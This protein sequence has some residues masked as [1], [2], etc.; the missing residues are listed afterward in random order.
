MSIFNY[1]AKN[2]AGQTIRGKVEAVN[3]QI[4]ADIL[5][6]KNLFVIKVS[7]KR[8]FFLI[9]KIIE[10]FFRRIKVK[11]EVIFFRQLSVLISAT[12]PLV[13]ALNILVKQTP[14]KTFQKVILDIAD[15]VEGGSRL[16]DSLAKYPQ[17]FNNFII[18]MIKSGETSGKLEEVLIYLANQ[19]EQDYDL[20][21]KIR[22][23][24]I[25][26]AFVFVMLIVVGVIVMVF[27]IPKLTT[28]FLESETKLPLATLILISISQFIVNFWWLLLFI[29]LVVFI[30]F[31]LYFKT[32][33]GRHQR[34]VLKLKLPLLGP[35][36]QRIYLVRFTRSFATL[37]TG[38]VMITKALE[39]TREVVG[40]TVYQGLIS[41]TIKE[42][43]DGNTLVSV[44]S[45]SPYIPVMLNQMISIGEEAGK[46]DVVLA[47]IT[48]FYTKEV[49]TLVK[50]FVTLLEPLVIV[51]IGLGVGVLVAA[52]I[53]PIYNL[54]SQF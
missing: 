46:L 26:P 9:D 43:E 20:I 5:R 47:K 52:V 45:K 10:K 19:Q 34:D 17:V 51:L 24:M 23:A 15:D 30:F 35:L 42:V 32:P 11:D 14:N 13:Q 44:F 53:L 54:A 18:S 6:E 33:F 50:N 8:H 27:V 4:A 28:I 38:G 1:K 31:Q 22:G 25:Y 29:L 16:S 39:V 49:E 3:E 7:R 36:F 48:D 12:I 41:K 21:S 2:R 40:N 37:L